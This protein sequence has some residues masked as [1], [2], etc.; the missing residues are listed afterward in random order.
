MLRLL[1]DEPELSRLS[2]NAITWAGRFQWDAV[3]EAMEEILDSVAAGSEPSAIRKID[4]V[5]G[6]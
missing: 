5:F 4:P 1:E 3:A 2:A 6:G